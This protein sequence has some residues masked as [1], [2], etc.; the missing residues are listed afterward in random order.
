MR[1]PVIAL[2]TDF[3]DEDW[4]VAS[5]KAVILSL[6]PR[7]RIVD[8]SHRIPSFDVD[9]AGFVL[10]VARESSAFER[11]K[12]GPGAVVRIARAGLKD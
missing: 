8:I 10:F 9:A 2:L 12:P 6:N 1:P 7:A 4:F 5:L 3:G 11:I